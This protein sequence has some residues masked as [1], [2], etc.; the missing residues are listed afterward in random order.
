[1][2]PVSKNISNSWNRNST[3]ARK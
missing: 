3:P 1:L 2:K